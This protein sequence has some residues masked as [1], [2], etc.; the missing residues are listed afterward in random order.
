M[1]TND[2]ALGLGN[3]PDGPLGDAEKGVVETVKAAGEMSGATS[4]LN[5][6][7]DAGS[8]VAGA[9]GNRVVQ[10]ARMGSED[11]GKLG[12]LMGTAV[13][14]GIGTGIGMEAGAEVGAIGGAVVGAVTDLFKGNMN[15]NGLNSSTPA[16]LE[17][18]TDELESK[19][20]G[21]L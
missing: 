7:G 17:A 1:P 21:L 12:A 13:E 5:V 2:I 9:L 6:V 3:Y 19:V 18:A 8:A 14:P 16:P 20:K 15:E 4:A 11:M 10:G